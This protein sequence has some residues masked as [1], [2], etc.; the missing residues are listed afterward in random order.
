MRARLSRLLI[1][2]AIASGREK[3][4]C[5][6]QNWD[7]DGSVLPPV[8]RPLYRWW[9]ELDAAAG[10]VPAKAQIDPTAIR[11]L[12]A[13][14]ALADIVREP[15]LDVRYRLA[16]S[17]LEKLY[18]G[19][20][21][22]RTLAQLYPR[23]IVDETLAAYACVAETCRPLYT[24]RTFRLLRIELGFDRLILPFSTHGTGEADL[25]LTCLVPS[26]DAIREASDWQCHA[27]DYE[28]EAA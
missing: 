12:L 22:G 27:T 4:E 14:V 2:T 3:S 7:D 13:Y 10:A 18:G 19:P 1:A 17:R 24:C 16:G 6:Q 25:A 21:T 28:P 26:S 20:M 23:G 11:G 9:L 5:A 8:F 15:R